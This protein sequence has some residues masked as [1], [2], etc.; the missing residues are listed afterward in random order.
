MSSCTWILHTSLY[1]DDLPPPLGAPTFTSVDE[2]EWT[3]ISLNPFLPH[4]T[5]TSY[6]VCVLK[7]IRTHIGR[8]KTGDF[9]GSSLLC[10]SGQLTTPGGP[11]GPN[12]GRDG[13]SKRRCKVTA[14]SWPQEVDGRRRRQAI[15]RGNRGHCEIPLSASWPLQPAV[16]AGRF[17]GLDLRR[18]LGPP[19]AG[20]VGSAFA[21][22]PSPE[23]RGGR[24]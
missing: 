6:L 10:G 8:V 15:R 5:V 1:P 12:E 7:F 18:F 4:P 2:S 20:T 23:L 21:S 16:I 24:K 22:T 14:S 13:R 9:S 17:A 3:G 11:G 19:V